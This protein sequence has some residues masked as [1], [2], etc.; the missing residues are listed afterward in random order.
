[1]VSLDDDT[2]ETRYQTEPT[3]GYVPETLY[4]RRWALTLLDRVL[5]RLSQEFAQAGK[6][7]VFEHLKAFLM[8]EQAGI[9]YAAAAVRL[10]LSEGAVKVS[11][12]RLRRRFRELFREEVAHTVSSREEID[13]EIR[14]LLAAVA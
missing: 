7:L 1:M 9:S 5:E 8:P 6:A 13:D 4:D 2:A 10:G 11:V 3:S 14:H 12:H